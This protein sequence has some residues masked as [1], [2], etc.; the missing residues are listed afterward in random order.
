MDEDEGDSE[1]AES[2][3]ED[4][5]MPSDSE[6]EEQKGG[7]ESDAESSS[8]EGKQGKKQAKKSGKKALR[9]QLDLEKSIREKEAQMRS[10]D[11]AAPTSVNDFERLL[12]ADYDQSYLWIQYMA[13]MLENLD[14]DAARRVAE[15]A[16]K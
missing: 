8:S 1:E 5:M 7:A 2:D 12:V 10:A 4:N 15:R 6:E 9:A 16:V 14:A 3:L 11:G 13:F